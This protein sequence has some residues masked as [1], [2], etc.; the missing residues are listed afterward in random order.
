MKMI[1]LFSMLIRNIQPTGSVHEWPSAPNRRKPRTSTNSPPTSGKF[2]QDASAFLVSVL[3]A[4][5]T[6]PA[7]AIT[8]TNARGGTNPECARAHLNSNTSL[9]A[10]PGLDSE[11]APRSPTDAER[12]GNTNQRNN[13]CN[14][15]SLR[16]TTLQKKRRR[17]LKTV[18]SSINLYL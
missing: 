1:S 7:S 10:R 17:R 5:L 4:L 3:G 2:F 16:N 6:L 8:V 14:E 9:D 15:I 18:R 13:K 11:A 12:S